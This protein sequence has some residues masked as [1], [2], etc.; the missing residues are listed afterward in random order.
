ML[1]RR[2][3]KLNFDFEVGKIQDS[4]DIT[5]VHLYVSL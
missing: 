1:G 5:S 2:E 3:Y 4:P